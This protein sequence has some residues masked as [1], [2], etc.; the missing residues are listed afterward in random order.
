MHLVGDVIRKDE[1]IAV[2]RQVLYHLVPA[3]LKSASHIAWR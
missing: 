2:V 1:D 3:E